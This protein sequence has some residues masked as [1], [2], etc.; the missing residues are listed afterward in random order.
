MSQQLHTLYYAA[1]SALHYRFWVLQ[2]F[3]LLLEINSNIMKIR[4]AAACISTI[5]ISLPIYS[6][7]IKSVPSM[8][9]MSSAKPSSVPW[10][11][12]TWEKLGSNKIKVWSCDSEINPG[13]SQSLQCT[14]MQ[15]CSTAARRGARG[16]ISANLRFMA[17]KSIDKHLL[18]QAAALLH[19]GHISF[20]LELWI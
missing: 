11:T 9:E 14:G 12:S 5:Y 6:I 18:W 3:S 16:L 1:V 15:H 13:Y 2:T 17:G 19:F 7:R 8:S 4:A 10:P 20:L